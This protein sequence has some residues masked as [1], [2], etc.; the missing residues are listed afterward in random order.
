[1][2][3]SVDHS[4][5]Q[6]SWE[7]TVLVAEQQS[8]FGDPPKPVTRR[9]PYRGEAPF[10]ASSDTSKAAAATADGGKK[11]T[12]RERVLQFVRSAGA[13][14]ATDDEISKATLLLRQSICPA[15]KVLMETGQL[16]DSGKRRVMSTGHPGA[17]WVAREYA[18]RA[19]GVAG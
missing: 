9:E 5:G 10:I 18:A 17:V 3:P 12:N 1:V 11:V 6:L 14:G 4:C 2:L 19:A 7:E 16:L 8:L 13:E 15:R